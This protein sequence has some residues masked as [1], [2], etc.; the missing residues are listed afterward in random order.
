M[1]SLLIICLNTLV[2]R[3][4]HFTLLSLNAVILRRA[5]QFGLLPLLITLSTAFTATAQTQAVF[6]KSDAVTQGNWASNYGADGYQIIN[7]AMSY[8]GYVN[9]SPSGQAAYTWNA[10]TS[11]PRALQKPNEADRIASTWYSNVSFDIN[12]NLND[13]AV[14]QVALYFLDW[15]AHARSQRIDIHDAANGA[16]LDSRTISNFADGLYLV[17]NL[18]GNLSLRLTRTGNDNA[19]VSGLFFGTNVPAPAVAPTVSFVKNDTTTQGNWKT[20]YGGDGYHLVNDAALYP[21]YAQLTVTGQAAYTWAASTTDARGLQKVTTAD[22]IAATWYTSDSLALDLNLTDG[23]T[24]PV[25]VYC[26]D[27]DYGGR[28]QK[29]EVLDL[30]NTVLDSRTIS[31]FTGGQ[32]LVW[33]LSGHVKLRVTRLG[34]P[35]AVL[36]GL[37]FGEGVIQRAPGPDT[38]PPI[39]SAVSAANVTSSSTSIKWTTN[40]FASSKLEYGTTTAYGN[41]LT[42]SQLVTSH[43]IGLSGLAPSTLYHYRVSATDAAGNIA[44]YKDITFTTASASFV[45]EPE[46]PRVWLDTAFVAPT[47]GVLTVNAGGDLQAALNAALPGDTIVLPAGA[48]FIAPSGGFVLPNKANPNNQWIVVRTATPSALPVSTRVNPAQAAAMPKLLSRDSSPAIT[49]AAGANFW[50]L[51]GLEVSLTS[52]ALPD[53]ITAGATTNYGLISLGSDAETY[54]GNQATDIVIDRCYIHGLPTKN[55]RRGVSLN[56]RRTAIIDSYLSDFHELGADSQAVCGWN[57]PGPF[58]LANNYLEGAGENILFGGADPSIANLVPADIEI[59]RNHLFKPRSWYANDPSFGGLAWS[60]KNLF[61]LKNARR[62]HVDGNVIENNWAHAQNGFA[63]L[64][65]VRNQEG[66]APWSVVEDVAFT[67]N[68]VRHTSSGVNILGRDNL[69][70]SGQA[71]RLKV[72]NNV[73]D[74]LDNNRW[75]GMGRFLQLT[76]TVEVRVEN[77]TIFHSGNLGTT[78]TNLSTPSNTGFI[79]RNNIAAHNSYGFIG[80]GTS[81]GNSTLNTYFPGALFTGNILAGGSA[82]AYPTGNYFPATLDNVGFINRA[83]GDYRLAATSL[84]KNAGADGNDPG[85]KIETLQAAIVGVVP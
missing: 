76:D 83:G 79:Y 74:D 36:S 37:F 42:L 78:Y 55:V 34:G 45:S 75:G 21:N 7:Q 40:E 2:S 38:T 66:S 82:L 64:F 47:G 23:K 43:E 85:A 67:N 77:N 65:T 61:E 69:Q 50:R 41:T 60:V 17:W 57:G 49:A 73:F 63:V 54:A 9:V 10:T 4:W 62:V 28:V 84:Y 13:G 71:R 51:I 48:T 32:Y 3:G 15:D 39:I 80:D 35:N 18:R 27:W 52:N 81:P 22:R 19:V 72:S 31:S 5:V 6:V 33:N 25:A 56:S 46:L 68:L 11:D 59:R 24:H 8:P 30:N 70:A 14:H 53:A 20:V 16:L 1:I 58:K 44:Q 12:L 29:L 26:L